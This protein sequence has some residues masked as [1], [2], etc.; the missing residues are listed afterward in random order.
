M[1]PEVVVLG[2][3]TREL[4]E[5]RELDALRGVLV[6]LGGGPPRR[7]DTTA[8]IVDLLR[9]ISTLNGRI[10]VVVSIVVLMSA[11]FSAAT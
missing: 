2:S 4:P 8:L 9:E 10:S 3:V 11:L 6:E 5:E 1:P 7:L